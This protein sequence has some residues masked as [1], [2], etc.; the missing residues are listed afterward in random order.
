MELIGFVRKMLTSR[1]WKSWL[2]SGGY[3]AGA[4]FVSCAVP[5]QAM[6]V[7]GFTQVTTCASC[8]TR[9]DFVAAGIQTANRFARPGTFLVISN[10]Y[11]RS[12]F[13][14]VTGEPAP[15]C[16]PSNGCNPYLINAAGTAETQGGA[17]MTSDS[18]LSQ[19]DKGIFAVDRKSPTVVTVSP[20]YSVTFINSLDEEVGP[21]IDQA[22][23]NKG[24]NWSTLPVG[25][26]VLVKF[27]DGT[28]AAFVKTNSQI[29]IHWAWFGFAW[30][31]NG[32]PINRGGGL[33]QN[34]NTS[35]TGG[36]SFRGVVSNGGSWELDIVGMD[37]C[38]TYE[39]ITVDGQLVVPPHDTGMEP[40]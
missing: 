27:Q 6:A 28:R 11:A 17:A 5:D 4:V 23:A 32:Q 24:I 38:T 2:V 30:N 10:A 9:A 40:C 29:T 16:Y 36:G 12:A 3:S 21:G 31:A 20:Q 34:P 7:N 26:I 8:Y 1:R 15:N 37:L 18:Q 33:I 35:G 13:V 39:M 22:L 19:L 25:A 14:A